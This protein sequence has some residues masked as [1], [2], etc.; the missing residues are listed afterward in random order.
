MEIPR[1]DQDRLLGGTQNVR[2]AQGLGT[3]KETLVARNQVWTQRR[4]GF[5]LTENYR[6]TKCF[7]LAAL[8]PP[9][10]LLMITQIALGQERN[11]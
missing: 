10:H 6:A 11:G 9:A 1:K 2:N 4:W 3:N 8:S 7:R 5:Q